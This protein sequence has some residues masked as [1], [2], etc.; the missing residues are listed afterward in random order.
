M[1][2]PTRH[3]SAKEA[4]HKGDAKLSILTFKAL[5][6]LDLR[7]NP[8]I[9]P[10]YSGGHFLD[11]CCITL[12]TYLNSRGAKARMWYGQQNFNHHLASR[13]NRD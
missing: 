11:F 13:R 7:E 1:H 5:I 6:F 3:V 2:L 9:C 10:L 12:N 8:T 4:I